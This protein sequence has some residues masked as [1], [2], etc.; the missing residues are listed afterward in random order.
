MI[1]TII[2]LLSGTR[3]DSFGT[4]MKEHPEWLPLDQQYY[5][6]L[7]NLQNELSTDQQKLLLSFEDASSALTGE[8]LTIVYQQGVKDGIALMKDLWLK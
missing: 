5:A 4:Q 1:E 7:K 6:C 8:E 3:M 2:K